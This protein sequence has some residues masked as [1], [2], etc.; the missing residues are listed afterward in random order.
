MILIPFY[1]ENREKLIKCDKTV[2]FMSIPIRSD[3]IIHYFQFL[4]FL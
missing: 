1:G 4:S 2:T 3:F